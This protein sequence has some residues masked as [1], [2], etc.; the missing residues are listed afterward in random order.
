MGK[1]SPA[2]P[3]TDS[4]PLLVERQKHD[5]NTQPKNWHLA[6]SL[7]VSLLLLSIA[8]EGPRSHQ[9]P[10]R[11]NFIVLLTDDQGWSSMSSSMD[12]AH[13]EY[14]SDYHETPRMDRFGDQGLRFTRGYAPAA[15]C[16]PSRRSIQFGQNPIQTGDA[17]FAERYN[18]LTHPRLTIPRMLHA[19]DPSYRTA[20]YGKWDLRADIFPEDLGYDESDGNTGNSHGDL[21]TDKQSKWTAVYLT[22]DPKRT[23]TL[24]DRAIQFM[25]RQQRAGRPF[26]LQVSY[27]ATHVDMQ[28]KPGTY[29]KYLKKQPGALHHQPA[30]AAMLADLDQGIGRLLDALDS[31]GITDN[32]YVVLLS[33]NGG[34]PAFPPP[35]GHHKL[36]PPA[37]GQPS[38]NNAPLR[39]GK[40]VL[41]EGGIRVPFLM[42][43]PGI[44]AHS[45]CRIPVSGCDLLPTIS[46]LA[47][48]QDSL[49]G[50][51]AG[52][53]LVPLVHNPWGNLRRPD[54]TLYFH[55]YE[56]SYGHSAILSGQ[57]KLVKFW[58]AGQVSLYDL[59]KD[60]EE[61]HD[62][63]DSLPEL[64]EILDRRLMHYLRQEHAEILFP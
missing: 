2:L 20:H 46:E 9:A 23:E 43:G 16:T 36:D 59:E 27:Y 31:L 10:K 25:E 18:P 54:S 37:Q 50:D 32:T 30:W 24:T 39:G 40:W 15:L 51:L 14:R 1:V 6:G 63:R 61:R 5:M 35:S 58:P 53:S 13:P 26:F 3:A 4:H 17:H 64:R 48:Y 44:P 21:M 62:L 12:S 55:R 41:Y 49:P 29:K 47:G 60:L 42:R 11:P 28:A 52:V 7:A 38:G 34:V 19:V 56:R 8:R 22:K 45:Y 33:D 57:Y